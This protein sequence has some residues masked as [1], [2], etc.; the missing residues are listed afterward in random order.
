MLQFW[1]PRLWPELTQGLWIKCAWL[2][3]NLKRQMN[4]GIDQAGQE[5]VFLMKRNK[6]EPVMLEKMYKHEVSSLYPQSPHL[7]LVLKSHCSCSKMKSRNERFPGAYGPAMALK[8]QTTDTTKN[9]VSDKVEGK[10]GWHLMSS[11][12]STSMLGHVGVCTLT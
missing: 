10:E 12:T 1:W 2:N 4:V 6:W 7:T 5:L 8:E 3:L 9:C 11:L